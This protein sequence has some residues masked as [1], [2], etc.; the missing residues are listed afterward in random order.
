VQVDIDGNVS[1]RGSG[2]FTLLIDGRPSVLENSEALRQIPAASIDRIEIITNPSVKYDP[3]GT[4][5]IIN[6]IM[7]K[8]IK[9]G[10]NGILNTS[11]G[12]GDKY[13]AG[14]LL[15]Y[16]LKKVNFFGGID[17]NKFHST[18]KGHSTNE[19]YLIDTTNYRNTDSQRKSTRMGYNVKG[20]IDY[21]VSDNSTVSLSGRYGYYGSD[22]N[23]S[24]NRYIYT[25]PVT[26]DD[27]SYSD[28]ASERKGNFYDAT[29]NFQHKFK[30][31]GHTLEAMAFFSRRIGDD[32]ETQSDYTTD[33][34]WNIIDQNPDINSTSEDDHSNNFRLKADYVRPL[35]TAGKLEAGFQSRIAKENATY[36]FQNYDYVSGSWIDN[37][38]Y[39]SQMDF[40]ES[41]HSLYAMFSS[42]WLGF[43]YQLGLRG[44]YTDRRIEDIQSP[45][46]YVLSLWDYFPTIH[47]SRELPLEQQLMLSYSRRINR[48]H[49]WDLDPFQNYMDPYNIRMGNPGLKPE[50]IDS[51][52]LGYQKKFSESFV[53]LD[54][55]YRITRNKMDEV[56]TLR[57]DG[58]MIHKDENLNKDYSLGAELSADLVLAKWLELFGS[59]DMFHYR[60]VGTL[61]DVPVDNKS[62]TWEGRFNVTVK[63]RGD[64]RFQ[65]TTRYEGPQVEAQGTEK[66]SFMANLAVRKDFLQR[67]LSVSLSARD[68]FKT[69][70]HE[71]STNGVGFYSHDRFT[72]EA[73]VVMLSLSYKINNYKKEL[74]KLENGEDRQD[75]GEETEF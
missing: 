1:L 9:A 46:P 2:S 75:N 25:L 56:T 18:G 50:Y 61:N 19:T 11:V 41:I 32:N 10:L 58:I 67:K 23:N 54:S 30:E 43:Q 8:N 34:N 68:L 38:M 53:A 57:S 31:N 74:D 26:T 48:P 42:K 72:R 27:Y 49:G 70:K 15:N 6:V 36:L 33:Q 28:N 64:L 40:R 45:Y 39:S 73:P 71:M 37:P 24:S 12:T 4:A 55:Y 21:F 22:M 44:E 69:A 47:L 63:L 66:G 17:Y 29:L 7:K 59:F 13:S 60:L 3:D 62:L 5:G 14:L 51:Y 35:G 16:R 20:G 65:L 52:E